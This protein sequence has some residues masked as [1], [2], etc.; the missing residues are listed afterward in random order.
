MTLT[1]GDLLAAHAVVDDT[2]TNRASTSGTRTAAPRRRTPT[3]Y[4]RDR[5]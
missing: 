1:A 3:R 5:P 2:R 4:R